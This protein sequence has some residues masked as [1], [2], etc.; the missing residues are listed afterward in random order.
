MESLLF[1]LNIL[2]A[3]PTLDMDQWT[4]V[5][6]VGRIGDKRVRTFKKWEEE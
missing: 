2:G 3:F 4:G 6:A 5:S 1:E